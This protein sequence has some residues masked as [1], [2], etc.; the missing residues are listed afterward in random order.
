MPEESSSEPFSINLS[1]TFT[2][3][4]L[5]PA[6]DYWTERLGITSEVH[7][8]P[9]NQVFQSLLD[10]SSP[11]HS[12]RAGLNVLLIRPEDWQR[13]GEIESQ[14][15]Q[16]ELRKNTS[17]FI[18]ALRSQAA[19]AASRYLVILTEPSVK[20]AENAALMALVKELCNEIALA[21]QSLNIPVVTARTLATYY[22]V[23]DP[24]DEIADREG[25]IPYTEQY[26]AALG[27][28]IARRIHAT[29]VPTPKVIVVDGD[30]TLWP[31]VAAEIGPAKLTI[32]PPFQAL[33]RFLKARK[34]AGMLLCI[35]SKN[36]EQ[37][38]RAVFAQAK[39]ML[40][41]SQDIVGWKVNWQPKSQN[42]AALADE[43]NLGLDS[44]LF[45]DDNPTEI[46]EVASQHPQVATVLLP[47]EAEEI[48]SF[49]NHHWLLDLPTAAATQED[50]N[51]TAMYQTMVA[52]S[53]S[54][55][56]ASD[57][58]TFLRELN[59]E[60]T[61]SPA[62]AESL[63]RV[64]QLTQ[65]TNQFNATTRRRSEIELTD[66][67]EKGYQ[68]TSV[69]VSDRFGDYGLVGTLITQVQGDSLLVDTLLLSCRVLGKG[70][71]Q[72]LLQELVQLA[73]NSGA[74][75]LDLPYQ[76][77]ERNTPVQQFLERVGS[78]YKLIEGDLTHYRLPLDI[79]EAGAQQKAVEQ[80]SST[81]QSAVEAS[82]S[83]L[84]SSSY[85]EIA[86]GFSLEA[87]AQAMSANRRPRPDLSEPFAAPN[88]DIERT[89][90]SLWQET[91]RVEKVGRHDRFAD[92]GGKSLQVIQLLA[93]LTRHFPQR[94]TAPE[95]FQKTTI[96]A[97]AEIFQQKAVT[98][99]E[100]RT[101]RDQS[102][103]SHDIAVV[104]MSCRLPKSPDVHQFWQNLLDGKECLTHLTDA[105]LLS[106]GVD[107]SSVRND[108][109]YVPVKGLMDDVENFDAKF[110]GIL[111]NEAK[112]MDPQHRVF[113]ELAWDC[114]ED[115]GYNS[116][117]YEGKIGVW[118]GNYL[119]TYALSNL[120]TDRQFLKDWI[121]AIQV[122]SLQAELGNDK[123]YLATRVAFK[124]NLR[125]P[126]M[127]VQS[128]CS[129]S[130]VA[131]SQACQSIRAGACDMAL[132][133]GITITL[134][135]KKGYYFT[136]DGIL[137]Q[138]GSCRA[139]D[140]KASGTVFSNGAGI[141]LLK[142]L[143]DALQDG[144]HIH[145]VIKGVAL[146]N[147]GGRK[148]SYTAPSID[149]QSSVITDAIHD[150]GIDAKTISYVEAHGTGTPLGDPI[151]IA[152]LT[153][154]YRE[155]GVTHNQEC[156][157]GTVKP[158]VGHLDV[159]SGVT[160]LIKTSFALEHG[161]LPGTL[162][163]Q[164]ANPKIDFANSPFRVEPTLTDWQPAK[165][166]RRAGISSFGV[167]GTNAHIVLEAPPKQESSVS[168]RPF[169]LFPIS[170]RSDEALSHA[171]ERL[172]S[173]CAGRSSLNPAD[174]SHTL[175]IGRKH[176][177]KR[178][179]M[180][181][182][183]L[184]DLA[185]AR[186]I[187]GSPKQID[188]PLVFMFPGQG[189]QTVG[190]GRDLYQ[191]EPYFR[192]ELD[193]CA[194]ILRP[195]LGED[196]RD[197]LFP[198]AEADQ[199]A[200]AL[201]IKQTIMA[202]PAIFVLS[203]C[204]AR[205]LMHWGLK[206]AALVGHSVGE[207][208]AA[209]LSQVVT[210][211]DAL[212]ILAHRGRLMQSVEPGGML[213][214][215]LCEQK[216]TPLI[217]EKLDLAAVNGPAL[218]VVAGPHDELEKFTALLESQE[219]AAKALHTSHGFHSWMMDP[220]IAPFRE[221]I[222]Q[223]KLSPPQIPIRST[224][225]TEWL[226]DE[227]ATDPDYWA[228]HVRRTVRFTQTA[229]H[230]CQEP[231]TTL[232]EIGPG[233]TL[234]TLSRQVAD[235]KAKQAIFS[236][237]GHA[238]DT[239]SD[240]L[241]FHLTLGQLWLHGHSIDWA[242]Y[243]AGE[244]RKRVPL[245][246]YPFERKRFWIDP[247]PLTDSIPLPG[248]LSGPA[249]QALPSVTAAAA[250]LPPSQPVP[251]M[252]TDRKPAILDEL[253]Q[254]LND[255]SGI[256]PEE[257]ESDASLIELGFDSLMLTQVSKE[258]GQ[259]F[260]VETTMRQLLASLPTLSDIVAYL[261]TEMPADKFQTAAAP[262]V[263]EQPATP[264][265]VAQVTPQLGGITAPQPM[266]PAIPQPFPVPT[267]DQN[268][269]VLQML[270]VQMQQMQFM[271]QQM[272][273]LSGIPTAA[274]PTATIAP[275]PASPIPVTAPIPAPKPT[276][277]S[278]QKSK[279]SG[280]ASGSTTS[281]NREADTELT[282]QQLKHLDNL[283]ARYVA[284]S[285]SSKE[286]TARYRKFHA[287]PRTVSGFNR[288]WKEMIYQLVVKKSKGSRLL[289]I[290]D[291]EYIDILNGFGPGFFG[292][293]P[294]FVLEAIRKQMDSGFEVGPQTPL[295]GETAQLFCEL[296]GAER[297]SFVCTGS[298]AVQAAMRL[299][300]TNTGR[301]KIAVFTKDYHGNFDEVLLRGSQTERKPRTFPSAPG[302]P[303]SAVSNM[304]VL[305]YG[306]E[307]SLEILKE[308]AH[309]LAAVMIEPV[310][311]RRPE[312]QPHDFIKE[313]RTLTEKSGS[314]L[315]FDEVICG[316]RDGPHGAQG[317]YGVQSDI[318]TYGKV[319]GGGLPIGIVAG[320]AKY[321]DTFD[322][323]T[324]QYGDDS[325]PEAGVTFFAGTFVRHPLGIAAANAVLKHIKQQGPAMWATLNA[326]AE[327]LY[328]TVDQFMVD[329][330]IPIRLPGL[331]SRFFVRVAEDC[332]Y[333][334]LL[335]FHL[336]QKGVFI[337][338][339]FPSY[340]TTAHT[341]DDIDYVIRAFQESVAELMEGG[342]FP[343]TDAIKLLESG[344]LNGPPALLAPTKKTASPS[345]PA[346]T[347]QA[348]A[349][350]RTSEL[351]L[352]E[353]QREIWLACQ[354]GQEA[355]CAFNE[356]TSLV[357]DGILNIEALTK[358]LN[359]AVGHH[360]A[361]RSS[362]DS[363]GDSWEAEPSI[364]IRIPFQDI[365]HLP[366][367]EKLTSIQLATETQ[368]FTPF[369][370]TQ[371]PLLRANL[372]KVGPSRHIL[373]LTAHHLV[374]DGWSF[375]VLIET[376]SD[377]YNAFNKSLPNPL[378]PA[379][380]FANYAIARHEKE[381]SEGTD[382][383]LDYWTAQFPDTV[384]VLNLPTD[385]PFPNHRTFSGATR[386][387][388]I[389]ADLLKSL[390]KAGAKSGA[391]LY[392]TT[393]TAFQLL[394][395]RLTGQ[396][397]I[398]IGIPAAGQSSQ[399]LENLVGHCVNFLPL[400]AKVPAHQPFNE[401]V[402]E[403]AARV[404]EAYEH[405]DCTYGQLVPRLKIQR[406]PGRMPLT[407]VGFNLERM[408]YF[409]PFDGLD[410]E[411]VD[412]PKSFVNQLLF[413][414]L[415]ES[416][417]GLSIEAHFNTAIFDQATIA[418]W[419]A[420]YRE[421]LTSI[422]NN[423]EG[424]TN[425]SPAGPLSA[426][427][428]KGRPL[429]LSANNVTD[430]PRTSTVQQIFEEIAAT[431]PDRIALQMRDW[432]IDY[433]TLNR[434]ANRLA[435]K[436]RE[437]GIT[438]NQPLPIVLDRSFDF[439]IGILATLKAGGGYVPIDPCYPAERIAALLQPLES[440]VI[441]TRSIFAEV[442]PATAKGTV[443][444]I[445]EVIND[446][447]ADDSKIANLL[448]TN[449][450][451]DLA[452]V[453]FTS[454][455]TGVSKGVEI[456]HRGIV[457]LVK[458]TNYATLD[459]EQVYLQASSL[460]FDA[461]TFEIW[462]PLLNGGRLVLLPPGTPSLE[463]IASEVRDH[464][465]TTLWLTAGL[466]QLVVDEKIETLAPL[467]QLLAGGDILSKSH[468]AK[469]LAKYPDLKVV[470]GYGPTE[471]TTFTCCHTITSAD[472]NNTSIP[473]GH[474]ISNTEVYL[475]D[476]DLNPLPPFTEGELY[477]GGD[478]L[479]RGYFKNTELTA[480]RFIANPFSTESSAKLYRSGDRAQYRPDGTIEFLGR[481]DNEIKI[482]GFRIDPNEI[483]EALC[484]HES[485]NQAR[486]LARGA[487]AGEKTLVGYIASQ[488][489]E[490]SV[491]KGFLQ[492]FLPS[493]LIPSRIVVLKSLPVT[494]NGK[495]DEQA[496]PAI[497]GT[498]PTHI[499]ALRAPQG[500]TEERMAELW[501]KALNLTEVPANRSFFDLGGH[502][503]QALKLF[504]QIAK[505]FG[506][507]LPLSTLFDNPTVEQLATR[508]Q[509]NEKEQAKKEPLQLAPLT[510][511]P[512]N[513]AALK[514]TGN[515][516]PLFCIHGGDGGTLIYRGLAEGFG[517]S[518]PI[519]ALEAPALSGD[520]EVLATVEETAA[521]YLAQIRTIQ[522]QGPYL[523]SGYCFGGIV[524]YEMAQ[525][526][527][528]AGEEIEL[529]CL[530]DTDN[531]SVAPRYLSLSERASRNWNED[532]SQ[533]W[534]GRVGKLSG[535]LSEGIVNKVKAKTE[536]AA[537]SVAASTGLEVN[538][539]LHTVIIREAHEK[540]MREYTPRDYTGDVVLFTAADQGDG[541]DYPPHLGWEGFVKGDLRLVTIPG[542]HLTIFQEPHVTE[543][544]RHLEEVLDSQK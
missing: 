490:E 98:G 198:P 266:A 230:F 18:E 199:E 88:G 162:H 503:L 512:S 170:A 178:Q 239:D 59:L 74:R 319:V 259:S 269:L 64:A 240:A 135:E 304:L 33:Q 2:A 200:A 97:Q 326:R 76:A 495:I 274:A 297:A 325:F 86:A 480:E 291:N 368:A 9:Y 270:N 499:E 531:P 348:A 402:Q 229:A 194:E 165:G 488:D 460:S 205:L 49:L 352:T 498:E 298:E 251:T 385:R 219:I 387:E 254:V 50:S 90:A 223:A 77:N 215:R 175:R 529:L 14:E 69:E 268:A 462:A 363:E 222:T 153:K 206:P 489:A 71:E 255:L 263:A 338:E 408:D 491:V 379:A 6:L 141:V 282:E 430:Y 454:G 42:I 520:S 250:P 393:L 461:A 173:Y 99:P 10:P 55:E 322:G 369:D 314:L 343:K 484:R 89:L 54:R 260:G 158:N 316:L 415:V 218:C 532:A 51:R 227:E 204:Q 160:A 485:I 20:V 224:V 453:M 496:L 404:L 305:D 335:F 450:P 367:T 478:G 424:P 232:I 417:N 146:N 330:E 481:T 422:A 203:Y 469:V 501:K 449:K 30:N 538:S 123:D 516:T 127:T 437:A 81:K 483:E 293:S 118:A 442:L 312:F 119:D 148:H 128:A 53:Q 139:F 116:E 221:V 400:R 147:D 365:S 92:L 75:T 475:L 83:L 28:L 31:G 214:V 399:G 145:A 411:F 236:T 284:R 318:S 390:R 193:R 452:Y 27:T 275:T 34:D 85:R 366:D 124:L 202:Q 389:D 273:L 357:F 511:Q 401:L 526:L 252:P 242:A 91:L 13:F 413:L 396:S 508:I 533:S 439:I 277:A 447:D 196:L 281:I 113:L 104:G 61:F 347:E 187:K 62:S 40:L 540:A 246:T 537:A 121:P 136:P 188:A 288:N 143:D 378:L 505:E 72:R 456:P 133:G 419:M 414:N 231:E 374:A 373:F 409:K 407:E 43:L 474:P 535:R 111:P 8:A 56:A 468:V 397:D 265:P 418:G 391:T 440:P 226:T 299:A 451:D 372:L 177:A 107:A 155:L 26:F 403:V 333:G 510:G 67:L 308:H 504:N 95:L 493:H 253:R 426:P 444:A 238:T 163:F 47:S 287:D 311:S 384:P 306:T 41:T 256:E 191:S 544:A 371:A 427:K 327:R 32:T 465:V 248:D 502:S 46:A 94:V 212:Q 528:E 23:P 353:A 182:G 289:D 472:L 96:A 267:G 486:V 58:E 441:L 350:I 151:E 101:T 302:V 195:L 79:A 345:I 159:A 192:Q 241:H 220:V 382:P 271:Q 470:N 340:I 471:N 336:R 22:P 300:R 209:T 103:K 539:K 208:V 494:E 7:F 421:I 137:S 161:K 459:A 87:L 129:T 65:R 11:F 39:G 406:L 388:S 464:G 24:L 174:V 225:T 243:T 12:E 383:H 355:S 154:A 307:E 140:E 134:P 410:T 216:L 329:N 25:H 473:I 294:D 519:Y 392:A 429:P 185:Q 45:I 29:I 106:A 518:R 342:F 247:T 530:F 341:D 542:E 370:L 82:R 435:L 416:K 292:H 428:K 320:K 110:F 477:F 455:S 295:V 467:Q 448:L 183:S 125:G 431:H 524:A 301:D 359:T 328:R 536:K 108:S 283:I 313:L 257:M 436:L 315:I 541:V 360:D 180:V 303:K 181:A 412:S 358:A 100:R 201:R 344:R 262:V 487:D 290:D 492:A 211:E 331:H 479:A 349:S 482:R 237:S 21:C 377:C 156:T 523:L 279:P 3:E 131:I 149:G 324:W 296:T 234:S 207:L 122:G 420:Q 117:D 73:R 126:A 346:A 517:N 138:D 17:E 543:F 364:E 432:S 15:S 184:T 186:A 120:V 354:L 190:M 534:A 152:A 150:A 323:G 210:L 142:R 167:G 261:D 362:F 19:P 176:F 443:I 361:L 112:L 506:K 310:Q 5:E 264:Q 16:A 213:S 37:D 63:P 438:P 334:N 169:H 309:E 386:Q 68:I 278:P 457:R 166:P 48:A 285:K 258:I 500:E 189:S 164:K 4:P 276:P 522:V 115:A 463:T 394:L 38:V 36:E 466:F 458:E 228:S 446:A 433:Q 398:V 1:A 425:P 423:P 172:A 235:K 272:Q 280:T 339:G 317:F 434:L 507:K 405:Q 525:Q 66:L 217:P 332:K 171:R 249:P 157:I 130:L 395:H 168:N 380:S 84:S 70:V 245:P 321:M 44:F 514:K 337:L 52:R 114:L 527:K 144:D 132:A 513:L 102:N 80:A 109:G 35:A 497:E 78:D 60:I 105:D 93:K 356:A 476:D 376:L 351:P 179:V 197:T 509:P 375:N 515:L 381:Q 521:L 233:Q 445:D 244:I 57:F 286:W